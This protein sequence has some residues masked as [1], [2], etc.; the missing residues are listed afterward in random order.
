MSGDANKEK[1]TSLLGLL[2]ELNSEELMA[3]SNQIPREFETRTTKELRE[4]LRK[5][6]PIKV[7]KE[8][9]LTKTDFLCI[10]SDSKNHQKMVPFSVVKALQKEG[11]L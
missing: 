11:L 6:E 5:R 10:V 1:L 3:V 4:L 8:V 2:K 7:V 9:S